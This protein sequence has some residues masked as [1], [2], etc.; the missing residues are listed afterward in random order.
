MLEEYE[1]NRCL[2]TV[3]MVGH[4]ERHTHTHVFTVTSNG[5][6]N[7]STCLTFLRTLSLSH[8]FMG[9]LPG[10]NNFNLSMPRAGVYLEMHAHTTAS[11]SQIFHLTP[12]QDL[13]ES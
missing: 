8:H 1:S 12:V 2:I 9:E 5:R 4:R 3:L 10:M 7:S 11:N 13:L 6:D